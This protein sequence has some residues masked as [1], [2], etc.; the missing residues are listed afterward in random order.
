MEPTTDIPT[1]S[2]APPAPA[3]LRRSGAGRLI[4]GVAAGLADYLDVDVAI[5]RIVFVA[6]ALLGGL[7]VPLYAAAWLL[8]P[9]EGAEETVA[10]ELLGHLRQR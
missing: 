7:G 4:A 5:V 3:T 8:V 1:A 6:L 10:D 2:M 9:E